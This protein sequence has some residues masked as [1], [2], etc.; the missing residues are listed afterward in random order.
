MNRQNIIVFDVD[1]TL[2]KGNLTLFFLKFLIKEN[3]FFL[4]KCLLALIKGALL[5]LWQLPHT[6]R[7]IL[8]KNSDVYKLNYV[9]VEKLTQFYQVI[10]KIFQDIDLLEEKLQT[11]ANALFAQDFFEK[12]TYPEGIAK[13]KHHLKNPNTV[14]VLLSG[15]LQELLNVF[16][17][18]ICKELTHENIDWKNRFFACGTILGSCPQDITPCIGYEKNRCLKNLLEQNGYHRY[19]LKFIYSDNNFMTDLPL[20]LEA[21]NGGALICKKSYLYKFLPKRLAC[22]IVFLPGW[23]R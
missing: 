19:S 12:H 4:R 22:S 13:L 18:F 14:V 21:T 15:S 8:V 9:L 16:F 11:K 23:K 2:I 3:F 7:K 5:I 17:R 6:S 1:H 20:L 10:F